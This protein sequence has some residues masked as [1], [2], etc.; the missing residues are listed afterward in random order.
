MFS[1]IRGRSGMWR[2]RSIDFLRA[3]MAASILSL[4]P[5]LTSAMAAKDEVR[6]GW[7]DNPSPGNATLYDRDGEWTVAMQGGHQ[8]EGDWPPNFAPAHYVKSRNASYGYGCACF[9]A[10]FDKAEHVVIAIKLSSSRDLKTCR[11]DQKLKQLE[12]KIQINPR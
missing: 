2:H 12:E 8:A 5:G 6:C 1:V 11:S 7:F 4:C 3:G 10:T 9:T